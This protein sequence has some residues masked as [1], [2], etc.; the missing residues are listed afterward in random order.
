MTWTPSPR[1]PWSEWL[2]NLILRDATAFMSLTPWRGA[3]TL[4]SLG[5]LRRLQPAAEKQLPNAWIGK[6]FVGA[7]RDARA[8]E[9]EHDPMVGIFQRAFGVLLDHQHGDTACA[10]FP[11]QP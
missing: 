10:H 3:A 8:P 11:K 2:T 4:L 6:N 5:H 9:L 1:P 7:I